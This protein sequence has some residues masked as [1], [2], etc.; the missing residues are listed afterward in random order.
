MVPGKRKGSEIEGEC[1]GVEGGHPEVWRG[2]S[3]TGRIRARGPFARGEGGRA[4]K[5][6][7]HKRPWRP[8]GVSGVKNGQPF[9]RVR[10]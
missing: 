3:T 5:G 1:L 4:L 9:F 7:Q 6:G 2:H 10:A 8:S